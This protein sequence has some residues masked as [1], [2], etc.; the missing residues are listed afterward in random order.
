EHI[1]VRTSSLGSSWRE[2]VHPV[3][4]TRHGPL[5]EIKGRTYALRWTALEKAPEIAT[6]ALLDR[7]SNWDEFREAL[8]EYPGPS[9]NFV[10]ADV[11]GHIG[12]YSAGRWPLRRS[13]DGSRP[14]PGASPDGDWVGYVPFDELPHVLDPP[15]GRIATANNR[16]VGADYP[17]KVTRG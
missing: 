3:Q 2:V 12:W 11:A 16:L 4:L 1:R 6:F 10:Y 7:A 5:V 13:G 9:Q 17:Y 15:D 14:Y 8:R